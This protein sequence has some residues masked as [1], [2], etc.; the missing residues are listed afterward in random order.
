MTASNQLF[1]I[2]ASHFH[3]APSNRELLVYSAKPDDT[4]SLSSFDEALTLKRYASLFH[5]FAY[6]II[7]SASGECLLIR[8]HLGVQ[9]L[10]YTHQSDRLIFGDTLTDIIENM[11]K[12]PSILES[13]IAQL[14]ADSP[15]YTDNTLYERIYR[16]EPGQMVRRR[17]NGC[18]TKVAFWQLE[19]EG[20]ILEYKQDEQYVEH[21]SALLQ[22]SIKQATHGAS[23]LAAEFS[24]GMDST[25]IYGACA[26]LGLNPPLF[27]HEPVSTAD[28]TTAYNPSYE[29]AVMT[30]YPSAVIHRVTAHDWDALR[31]L[32]Q[33]AH[34]FS[35]APPYLFEVFAQPL[36][37][38]VSS[39]GHH[40]LL[41]GFGG[42]QGVSSPVPAR[43][44]V[45]MLLHQKHL[46]DA[47]LAT[48]PAPLMR[49]F[50]LLFQSAHPSLH[51]FTQSAKKYKNG[52]VIT[53]HAYH[54]DYFKTLRHMEWSF[55][56][57]PNS[58]E[59]RMRIEYSSLVAKKMG[60]DYRYPLLH[61]NLL[62]FFLSLPVSQKRHQGVGRYLMRRYLAS[63][64]PNAPFNVYQKKEGLTII[65]TLDAFKAQ[66]ARGVFQDAFGSRP[67]KHLT[68]DDSSD[69]AMIKNI[70]AFMLNEC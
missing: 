34:W 10:Y 48:A 13:E 51:H 23:S 31:V 63:L 44:I 41:S 43:F 14:F 24:A 50:M 46:R 61:P 9:P 18:I 33:Y 68:Q 8:D 27:M 3:V 36:H 6:V 38:A 22:E 56:Q 25:A 16:V 32:K 15:C 64:L 29:R 21:F 60:F 49:R 28:Q 52:S 53:Q 4:L 35:G 45:P 57:G 62:A 69:K 12:K 66:W 40:R 26:S 19:L 67:F 47:W 17:A 65:P 54:R 20:E 55:L 58:H 37:Q 42:D 39:A 11:P 59:L 2:N 70:Q 7:D 5:P 30:H 1:F